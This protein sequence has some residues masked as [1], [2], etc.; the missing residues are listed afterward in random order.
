MASSIWTLILVS[1]DLKEA[2][3]AL[4]PPEFFLGRGGER[5]KPDLVI[6]RR[7]QSLYLDDRVPNAN[8]KF[9]GKILAIFAA[10]DG[11][12]PVNVIEWWANIL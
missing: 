1:A 10:E 9:R 4:V 7:G 8:D 12:P 2:R 11:R 3:H 5:K 6:F